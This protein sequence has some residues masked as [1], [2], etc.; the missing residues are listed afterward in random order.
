MSG[1][2]EELAWQEERYK[3]VSADQDKLQELKK[4]DDDIVASNV[5]IGGVLSSPSFQ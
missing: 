3:Y 2:Q 5:V 1:G 4:A